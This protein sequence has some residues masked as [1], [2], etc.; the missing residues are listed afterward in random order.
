MTKKH[1]I[2]HM[3]LAAFCLAIC[4]MLPIVFGSVP[5][6]NR[7][8]LPMHIGV[9]LCAYVAD[10]RWA[11]AVGFIAPL[12][13]FVLTG[14]PVIYPTAIA[15]AFELATYGFI[16]GLLNG[17]LPK[18]PGFI[19]VSLIAAMIAGRA[20]SGLVNMILLG[21]QGQAYT[22]QT[23]IAASVINAWPGIVMHIVLIPILIMS[24]RRAKLIDQPH[25]HDH[26]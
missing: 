15:M 4:I 16:C 10:R 24:L 18:K 19:Y 20:V 6:V 12:L 2:R 17:L 23:F 11:A 13:K 26:G 7:R 21:M 25:H 5:V 8:M 14:V 1:S 3:V 9:F 22:W